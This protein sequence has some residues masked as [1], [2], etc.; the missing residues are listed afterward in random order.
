MMNKLQKIQLKLFL[1]EKTKDKSKPQILSLLAK[2]KISYSSYYRW[3]KEDLEKQLEKEVAWRKIVHFIYPSEDSFDNLRI[4]LKENGYSPSIRELRD[5]IREEDLSKK[6]GRPPVSIKEE[7]IS[8]LK[9]L[10]KANEYNARIIPVPDLEAYKIRR[11]VSLGHLYPY[12]PEEG[13]LPLRIRMD[14]VFMEGPWRDIEGNNK[15][16]SCSDIGDT[17][18]LVPYKE[19]NGKWTLKLFPENKGTPKTHRSGIILIFLNP[20]FYEAKIHEHCVQP[21]TS[22]PRFKSKRWKSSFLKGYQHALPVPY[23]GRDIFS[24]SSGR[25]NPASNYKF[26]TLQEHIEHIT[27]NDILQKEHPFSPQNLKNTL[28]RNLEDIITTRNRSIDIRTKLNQLHSLKQLDLTW[29]LETI[30]EYM[31]RFTNS[32]RRSPIRFP[33]DW[34]QAWFE[35]KEYKV[36]IGSHQRYT[37]SGIDDL[38]NK[39]VPIPKD[40]NSLLENSKIFH[41][42]LHNYKNK[43][44]QPKVLPLSLYAPFDS[45]QTLFSHLNMSLDAVDFLPLFLK[46]L[47]EVRKINYPDFDFP[48]YEPAINFKTRED[49]DTSGFARCTVKINKEE[50]AMLFFALGAYPYWIR[51][52]GPFIDIY[53]QT[54]DLAPSEV[55]RNK[56]NLIE[57]LLNNLGQYRGLVTLCEEDGEPVFEYNCSNS[58]YWN[59]ERRSRLINYDLESLRKVAAEIE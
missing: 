2:E 40:K 5:F 45:D 51:K 49:S 35:T 10:H 29:K 58:F 41:Q 14:A 56:A 15:S 9:Y 1:L 24:F 38:F 30:E 31:K 17:A 20:C 13:H 27:S 57:E 26:S 34:F 11:I 54:I 3:Q 43:G 28:E 52:E 39:E 46:K 19:P 25:W 8:L 7:D 44:I 23:I 37:S 18:R 50:D 21:Q 4:R 59:E 32:H 48:I 16:K 47:E 53:G 36:K 22:V 33:N 6:R 42:Y 55:E 12:Q